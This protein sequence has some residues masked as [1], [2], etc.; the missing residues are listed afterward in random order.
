MLNELHSLRRVLPKLR[1]NPERAASPASSWLR[2]KS[3]EWIFVTTLTVH[4]LAHTFRTG[5]AID[6]IQGVLL[7]MLPCKHFRQATAAA[8]VP[9]CQII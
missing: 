1:L 7:Q 6:N 3:D 8:L 2:S 5:V 4:R 9:V